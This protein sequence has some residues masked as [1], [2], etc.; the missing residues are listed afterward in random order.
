[1]HLLNGQILPALSQWQGV[2]FILAGLA[3]ASALRLLRRRHPW[4]PKR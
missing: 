1:M 4:A 3:L 2:A